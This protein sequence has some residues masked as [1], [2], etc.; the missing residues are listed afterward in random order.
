MVSVK[1]RGRIYSPEAS[2]GMTTD[3]YAGIDV[4]LKAS[5]ICVE[6]GTGKIVREAK[7]ASEP[8]ALILFFR[9][10]GLGLTRIWLEADPLSQWLYAGLQKA[11]CRIELL[12]TR[13]VRDALRLSRDAL[14]DHDRAQLQILSGG[15]V[16]PTTDRRVSRQRDLATGLTKVRYRRV[17]PE[18]CEAVFR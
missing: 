17:R 7:V 8:K 13:H 16:P 2:S 14:R 4:S 15:S 12:E 5:S 18:K 1:K 9:S 10:F 6:D 3:Y 11:G